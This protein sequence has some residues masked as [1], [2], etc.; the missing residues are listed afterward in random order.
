[1]LT[2][3]FKSVVPDLNYSRKNILLKPISLIYGLIT[4]IRNWLYDNGISKSTSFRLPIISVGNLA[5]GGTGKTPH[6]EYIVNLFGNNAQIATLSRGYK[7]KTKGFVLA[8]ENSDSKE[9]GDEPYQIY[10]KNKHLH[11]AVDEKRVHG[12][13]KLREI[14]PELELILLD[15]AFQHRQIKAGLSILLTDYSNLYTRDT[16]LPTGNLRESKKGSKRAD[17]I[18][19][20]KCPEQMPSIDMRLIETELKLL[21]Y[22]SLYFSNYRYS[23][24]EPVFPDKIVDKTNLELVKKSK[25][26]ILL[27]AGIAH[28]QALCTYLNQ[29]TSTFDA[30]IF[31]DHYS[32]QRKDIKLINEKLDK[33]N[34]TDKIIIVTEKDAARIV[35]Q[36]DEW[37]SFQYLLY[38]LPIKVNILNNQESN[39]K[40]KIYNY[41]TEDSRNS[42]L[43]KVENKNKS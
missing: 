9:I 24:I 11:V 33:L 18:I 14:F 3:I 42:R 32:F 34:T 19:V 37:S 7:R 27:V 5:V 20:T 13:T 39:F 23:G 12:V 28:P 22:Q 30:L 35:S 26:A 29:Y 43:F 41:V 16:Y 1:M 4:G 31:P 17:I 38:K 8:N 36:A 40:T 25:T 15:D 21:P 6:V 2:L 10:I